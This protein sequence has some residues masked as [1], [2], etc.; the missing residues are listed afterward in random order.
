NKEIMFSEQA[1]HMFGFD[2]E[3]RVT[4]GLLESRVHP[5]DQALLA[6]K[7]ALSRADLYNHS[8]EYRLQMPNGTIKYLR[9]NTCGTRGRRGRLESVGAIHDVTERRLSEEALGNVQ[10]E[11]AHMT[12]VASLG[13]LTA[14]IAHEVNQP[15]SGII[16]NAN[17]CL[18]MLSADP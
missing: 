6:E 5:E 8:F 18:R 4:L 2:R 10:S 1:R 11:L 7:V 13:A 16:T 17:T 14:S 3:T 9:M 12:R 15:L